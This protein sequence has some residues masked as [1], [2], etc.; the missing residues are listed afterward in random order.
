VTERRAEAEQARRLAERALG[1]P[2]S[3]LLASA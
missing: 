2:L 3:K 1:R